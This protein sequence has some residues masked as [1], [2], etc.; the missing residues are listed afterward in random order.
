MIGLRSAAEPLNEMA[1]LGLAKGWLSNLKKILDEELDFISQTEIPWLLKFDNVDNPS[2]LFDYKHLST[3]SVLVTSRLLLTKA[4]DDS[5]Q[6]CPK[7]STPS[8][9]FDVEKAARFL[10]EL[11]PDS[12]Q[13]ERSLLIAEKLGGL[14]LV[15]LAL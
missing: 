14:P 13:V 9:T 5:G 3:S 1:S 6:L 2:I 4:R 11:T 15:T 10:R 8:A 12:G 7:I